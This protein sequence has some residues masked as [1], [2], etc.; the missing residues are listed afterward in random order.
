[1]GK[2]RSTKKSCCK[3]FG[4]YLREYSN[5]SGIHGVQYFGEKRTYF[6][7]IWWFI[8]FVI[9]L[10]SC[11]YAILEVYHKWIRSP[12]IVT[13]ATQETQIY[14]IPFPAV[15]ICPESKTN[16]SLYNHTNIT[17][18]IIENVDL[19]EDEQN[20]LN[21]IS[22]VCDHGPHT[23]GFA[24][25]KFIDENFYEVLAKVNCR[26]PLNECEYMGRRVQC[27]TIFVP[28]ITD[29]GICYS[30]NIL[31]KSDIFKDFVVSNLNFHKADKTNNDWTIE[32]GYAKHLGKHTYPRRA[33]F[34]GLKN[35]LSVSFRSTRED[36]DA[37]CKSGLQGYK[38]PENEVV[39]AGVN[40]SMI[41]T[42]NTLKNYDVAKRNC[43]FSYEKDLHFFK[44]YTI[45][46]C[47]IECLTNFTL[48]Y[49]GCVGFYMPRENGT[50]ICGT[51]L[52]IQICMLEAADKLQ[53]LNLPDFS[54]Q[55]ET[56]THQFH[57]N[58]TACDCLPMCS[59]L[60]YNVELSQS[61]WNWLS[62]FRARATNRT[63]IDPSGVSVSK[64]I[65]FF[66][67]SDFI[68]SERNELYGPLDFLA[69]FGGLLGLF[70]GFS[71]LSL[72]EIV[73]FLTIRIC[74][75]VKLYGH[76]SGNDN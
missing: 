56:K 68:Y 15:T 28:I 10:S 52:G 72:M 50:K 22:L 73:Y 35:G 2:N 51:D 12:V 25:G 45:R 11:V 8:V 7:K 19:T 16:Q 58:F 57:G 27:D 69:N 6:E 5:F 66:K 75:N 38:V 29:D 31:D 36:I 76:W 30:F 59:D 53:T 44:I 18:K 26:S 43:Y 70:T 3:R 1:M 34:S 20:N 48:Y 17:R 67:T 32:T 13:F 71:L 14:S 61:R 41:T 23:W 46:N 21:Y 39:I 62:A 74:C 37:S 64:L 40:P 65:I 49:C 4:K 24:W 33:L 47:K 55:N 9:A 54:S 42:S 63:R 60:T